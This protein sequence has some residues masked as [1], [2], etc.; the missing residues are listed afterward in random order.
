M[1]ERIKALMRSYGVDI[2][3][4]DQFLDDL[5]YMLNN[6]KEASCPLC[7][8]SE[9]LHINID[10]NHSPKID[11]VLCNECGNYFK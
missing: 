1:K 10:Y 6:G 9:N 5:I 4:E 8:E 7:G 11:N 3:N 2:E